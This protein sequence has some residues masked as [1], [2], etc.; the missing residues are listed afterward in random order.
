MNKIKNY[1]GTEIGKFE[2]LNQ[3]R[4]NNKTY[5]YCKCKKCGKEKWIA[6]GYVKRTK[7]CEFNHSSTEF[8][9]LDLTNQTI[10]NILI[11]EKTEQ[12]KRGSVIWKC[13]CFCGK[14]F[15]APLYRIKNGEIKSCGCKRKVYRKENFK[16]LQE[17][18]NKNYLYGT[19]LPLIK[20]PKIR[21]NNKSGINGVHKKGSRWIASIMLANH[22]YKLGSFDNIEKAEK[23]RKEAEEEYFKPILEKYKRRCL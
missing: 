7:C 12:R 23:A 15:Y 14:V 13:R 6:Q 4:E 21:S 20:N 10:N 17:A 9:P 5:L 11:L 3:K 19:Y 1:I 22:C 8:K 16:K 2:I 18:C